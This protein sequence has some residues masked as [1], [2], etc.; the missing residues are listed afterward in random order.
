[1]PF[2][3]AATVCGASGGCAEHVSNSQMLSLAFIFG[4]PIAIVL[5]LPRLHRV[6]TAGPSPHAG[7]SFCFSMVPLAWAKNGSLFVAWLLIAA[8][9]PIFFMLLSAP[10]PCATALGNCATISCASGNDYFQGYVFMFVTLTLC[11]VVLGRDVATLPSGGTRTYLLGG[12]LAIVLTGIFPEHF[13]R[14]N[15]EAAGGGVIYAG[16]ISLHLLGLLIATNAFVVLPYF[17]LLAHALRQRHHSIWIDW[18]R[19]VLI[20]SVHFLSLVG[21]GSAFA[22]LRTLPDNSDYCAPF[23]HDPAGCAAWPNLT[24]DACERVASLAMHG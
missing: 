23:K 19:I 16:A 14:G 18:R 13:E 12:A 15:S 6:T 17:R 21:F 11:S 7:H 8:V 24:V 20:R 4:L 2:C 3:A 9:L 10:L 22:A 1:M 5:V